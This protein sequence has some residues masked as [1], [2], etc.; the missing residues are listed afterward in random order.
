MRVNRIAVALLTVAALGITLFG[1]GRADRAAGTPAPSFQPTACPEGVFPADRDVD[2][3]FI[4]VPEDR[5][6][7][8]GRRSTWPRRSST[9]PPPA[10]RPI[11]SCSSPAVPASAPSL[12][13]AS[14][15]T[16]PARRTPRT[17]T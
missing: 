6:A 11:P 15:C 5:T 14:T 3:G 16:S 12:R 9:R 10:R 13:S 1:P 8:T 2:Y 7:R 4:R 17:T